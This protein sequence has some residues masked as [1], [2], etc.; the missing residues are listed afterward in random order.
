MWRGSITVYFGNSLKSYAPVGIGL[1]I[2]IEPIWARPVARKATRYS[3]RDGAS[4]NKSILFLFYFYGR[5]ESS[6]SIGI[7]PSKRKSAES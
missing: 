2:S 7:R 3:L 1:G 5:D 4:I 6:Y